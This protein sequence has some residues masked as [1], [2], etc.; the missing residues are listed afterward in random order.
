V[1]AYLIFIGQR[2]WSFTI[3]NWSLKK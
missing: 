1:L 2:F 3:H